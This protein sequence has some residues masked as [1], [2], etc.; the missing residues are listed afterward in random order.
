MWVYPYH[1]ASRSAKVLANELGAKRK[2]TT[3]P[4]SDG[5]KRVVLNWGNPRTPPWDDDN[6]TWIN[7]P[8]KV[9]IASNKKEALEILGEFG[10]R[11]TNNREQA[12]HWLKKGI[13]VVCRHL[14]RASGGK[15]IQIV[16][17]DDDVGV[18]AAPLYVQYVKKQHEYRVHIKGNKIFDIQQ[19]RRKLDNENPNYQ[20]R[21]HE[22]GWVFCRDDLS[23]RDDLLDIAVAS[24]GKFGLDFGAVDVIYNEHYDKH[25]VLEVNTAPGLEGTT[26]NKYL[27]QFNGR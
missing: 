3:K 13:S 25:Y 2:V 19:K 17:P 20:V 11:S 8:E 9:A 6:I 14:L 4:F 26:L 24:V 1:I 7:H 23:Y 10:P 27:E 15:G 18:P 12:N 22:N 21:N 16:N 5:K